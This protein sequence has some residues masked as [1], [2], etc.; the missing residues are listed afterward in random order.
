MAIPRLPL[1]ALAI[2]AAIPARADG[3]PADARPDTV[4]IRSGTLTLHALLWRPAGRGP[5]PA[6]LF[7]TAADPPMRR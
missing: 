2:A 4:E 6:V 1:V 7:I 5:F 3:Q